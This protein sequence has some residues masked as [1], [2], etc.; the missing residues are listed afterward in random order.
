MLS[1]REWLHLHLRYGDMLSIL[2]RRYGSLGLHCE[3]AISPM[4][5]SLNGRNLILIQVYLYEMQERRWGSYSSQHVPWIQLYLVSSLTSGL[6]MRREWL[7]TN[8]SYRTLWINRTQQV[9]PILHRFTSTRLRITYLVNQFS[10]FV[11]IDECGQSH[12]IR[13]HSCLFHIFKDLLSCN[14]IIFLS[15]RY[16]QRSVD[17]LL[18]R[19]SLS[20]YL[21]K[22]GFTLIHS[23]RFG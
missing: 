20:L 13:L 10:S 22:Y 12:T 3:V 21:C 8:A 5:Q 7:H 18:H 6:F 23:S 14:W 1:V 16:H 2:L 4:F 11:S 17:I 15:I 9:A 19:Q